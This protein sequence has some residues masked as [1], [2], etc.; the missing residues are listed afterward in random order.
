[1]KYLI[2]FLKQAFFITL[3][4]LFLGQI[5]DSI[6]PGFVTQTVS[7]DSLLFLAMLVGVAWGVVSWHTTHFEHKIQA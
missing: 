5:L 4:A 2:F 1:M 7:F 3:T 6:F